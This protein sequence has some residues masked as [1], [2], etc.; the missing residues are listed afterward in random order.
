M[1]QPAIDLHIGELL[2]RNLPYR[3][4]YQIASAV[5][6]ALIRLLSEHGLPPAL[7]HGGTIPHIGI[8][9]LQ[10]TAEAQADVVGK[11]I[12]QAI[13]NHLSDIVPAD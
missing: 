10:V 1:K 8:E 12:A 6:Q 2:L 7:A 13:Y 11:Q 4:R 3:Q 9:H 5:E